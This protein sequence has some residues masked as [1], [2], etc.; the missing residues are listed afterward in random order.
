MKRVLYIFLLIAAI[1][2][3]IRA[4]S[5]FDEPKWTKFEP[6]RE[7][8]SLDLPNPGV[9]FLGR[10]SDQVLNAQYHAV[11]NKTYFAIFSHDN[12]DNSALRL[13]MGLLANDEV[14]P[15]DVEI[16]GIKGKR[17][18]FKG[19]DDYEHS[20]IA[21][22]AP[23]HFYIFHV[24]SETRGNPM[25]ETFLDSIKL[26][27]QAAKAAEPPAESGSSPA[28]ARDD[29]LKKP[30]SGY[31]S[32]GGGRMEPEGAIAPPKYA[33]V[34]SAVTIL[35]KPRPGYTDLARRYMVSGT[36]KLRITFER[37]GVIG[38]ITTLAKLP[39][40]LT[41]NAISAAR[42]IK[43]SPALRRGDPYSVTKVLEFNFTLY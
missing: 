32:S 40:G 8:F 4:Q 27:R 7:E 20:L 26:N 10:N 2:C 3:A 5:D 18:D 29:I 21:I 24:I 14:V 25:I 9:V 43:F 1:S 39:F 12:S 31:G 13:I 34:D 42:N 38:N 23:A 6:E 16:D 28:T 30:G 35:S 22:Q 15:K 37:N 36:V 11:Q 41:Q 17:Y 33:K 19:A